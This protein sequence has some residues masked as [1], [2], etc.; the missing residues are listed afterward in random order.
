M[1]ELG[2]SIIKKMAKGNMHVG[3]E[4]VDLGLPSGTLWA[5][6]NI[7]SQE[8]YKNGGYC[9]WGETE[10]LPY[11][12]GRSHTYNEYKFKSQHDSY[13]ISHPPFT[14]YTLIDG[15]INLLK[16]DDAASVMWGGAWRVPSPDDFNELFNN[17]TETF[18][19]IHS[20]RCSIFTSKM[21]G[22]SIIFP[23]TGSVYWYENGIDDKN[24]LTY[25]W[26]NSLAERYNNQYMEFAYHAF[27][28]YRWPNKISSI[29]RCFGC[30]IR[31]VVKLS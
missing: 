1:E 8:P 30:S 17:T 9:G 10:V 24:N 26:T 21:N 19:I 25:L 14:K 29:P 15:M 22:N 6:C 11:N 20:R 28:G 4:F 12:S 31:P 2:I 18:K 7:G 3:H 13:N 27:I 16:E 23:L 5:T